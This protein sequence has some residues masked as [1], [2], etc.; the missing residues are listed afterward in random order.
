MAYISKEAAAEAL[1]AEVGSVTK[2][3]VTK[4]LEG[5]LASQWKKSS[6]VSRIL[7]RLFPSSIPFTI[8]RR[9]I[10]VRNV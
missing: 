8:S 4:H 6:S 1:I 9:Q 5:G 7:S 10:E 2:N 3:V